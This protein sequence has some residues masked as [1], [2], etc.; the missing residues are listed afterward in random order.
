MESNSVK[1]GLSTKSTD[2]LALHQLRRNL[3]KLGKNQDQ[4]L[5]G[6]FILII[7][8]H[9]DDFFLSYRIW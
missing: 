4:A 6:Q 7:L 2:E 8:F 5:K 9:T 3:F 1:F